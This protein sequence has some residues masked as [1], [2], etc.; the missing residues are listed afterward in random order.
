MNPPWISFLDCDGNMQ[1]QR[2]RQYRRE[3]YPC[4]LKINHFLFWKE[5]TVK[6]Q[7][8]HILYV[9]STCLQCT[10]DYAV[11]VA[12]FYIYISYIYT[13]IKLKVLST[14]I[15]QRTLFAY[16]GC[17]RCTYCPMWE[18]NGLHIIW[19]TVHILF[20]RNTVA[21]IKGSKHRYCNIKCSQQNASC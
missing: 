14:Q 18:V 9:S 12:C 5:S 16:E 4:W 21:T 10:A 17:Y 11:R 7:G 3:K 13:N 2:Q 15:A 19:L 1:T 8:L 20:A 6:C